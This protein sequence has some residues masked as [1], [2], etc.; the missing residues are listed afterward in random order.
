MRQSPNEPVRC[1]LRCGV[2]M[3]LITAACGASGSPSAEARPAQLPTQPQRNAASAPRP[4]AGSP[5]NVGNGENSPAP[6]SVASTREGSA[7]APQAPGLGTFT[8]LVLRGVP[9]GPGGSRICDRTSFRFTWNVAEQNW[10]T[11]TCLPD[12][13]TYNTFHTEHKSGRVNGALAQR[14]QQAAAAITLTDGPVE[15]WDDGGETLLE[16]M[17]TDAPIEMFTVGAKV[18]GGRRHRLGVAN[19]VDALLAIA[20][21]LAEATP[22]KRAP[23]KPTPTR[24]TPAQPTN[25]AVPMLD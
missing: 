19:H 14:L 6:S 9:G 17:R 15:E 2:L 18:A 11:E 23:A 7:A 5:Q 4:I 24:R 1:L 8:A 21:E 10:R 16:V 22:A 13:K 12:D 3:M 25:R 20:T